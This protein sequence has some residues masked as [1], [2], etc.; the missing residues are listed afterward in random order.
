M[1]YEGAEVRVKGTPSVVWEG[2][3]RHTPKGLG[4]GVWAFH[5]TES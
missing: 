3:L 2:V 4:Q 1:E 5:L